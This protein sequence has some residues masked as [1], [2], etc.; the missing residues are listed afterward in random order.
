MPGHLVENP[1]R[2]AMHQFAAAALPAMS[3]SATSAQRA[4][5]VV[6]AARAIDQIV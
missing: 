3:L 2:T 6:D 4:Q 1:G 5:T